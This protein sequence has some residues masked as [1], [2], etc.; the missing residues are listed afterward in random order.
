MSVDHKPNS[1][2][3]RTRIEQAGGVVVWAGTWRVAGVLAVSRAFGDRCG[4]ALSQLPAGWGVCRSACLA[5][6][7]LGLPSLQ[8]G[9]PPRAVQPP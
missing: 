7:S 8:P 6:F 9:L 3:E 2:E 1:K 5:P 4:G